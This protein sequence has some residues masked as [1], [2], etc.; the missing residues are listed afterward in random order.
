MEKVFELR[1]QRSGI[2]LS[3]VSAVCHFSLWRYFFN[4]Y[5]TIHA[6]VI[7]VFIQSFLASCIVPKDQVKNGILR[8]HACNNFKDGR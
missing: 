2:Y 6:I 1:Y 3:L 7:A 4:S 5:I 8:P